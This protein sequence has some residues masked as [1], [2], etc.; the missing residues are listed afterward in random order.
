MKPM[1]KQLQK[2]IYQ[3][4][5][6]LLMTMTA[7]NMKQDKAPVNDEPTTVTARA[8]NHGNG[9]GYVVLLNDKLFIKQEHIPAIEGN[10]TFVKE[11]D[12]LKVAGLVV[13]KLK[14]NGKPTIAVEELQQ[15]GIEGVQ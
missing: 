2:T 11:T 5:L 12:A 15:L 13:A 14:K 9:W 6:I 4:P 1:I 7:C 10:K 3:L 8:F